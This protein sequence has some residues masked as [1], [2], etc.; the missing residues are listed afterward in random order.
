MKL[1]RKSRSFRNFLTVSALVLGL[2][3]C[4][5]GKPYRLMAEAVR[6]PERPAVFVQDKRARLNLRRA[7][8]L[9]VPDTTLSVSPYVS[10]GHAYLVGWVDNEEERVA[11][12][13]AAQSVQGLLSVEP[14]LPLKPTG[15]DAP[16]STSEL[17]LKTKVV[18]SILAA[19][20]SEK[21]NI[22]VQ[23]LGTHAVLIGAVNSTED[24]QEAETAAKET[25]GISG[26][27]NFLI[28]PSANDA[29]R[30]GGFLR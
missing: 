7:L 26:V 24:I 1:K 12:E 16:D 28:V 17:E 20:R 13:K 8:V 21:I 18:A 29:K 5:G 11:L 27:T 3:S 9:A 22:S 15:P 19:S 10:G 30:F 25:S 2:L 4:G 6:S 23:V 14:Y